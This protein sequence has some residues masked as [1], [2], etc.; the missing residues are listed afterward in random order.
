MMEV[1]KV[2]WSIIILCF[3]LEILFADEQSRLFFFLLAFE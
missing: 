2:G 3:V 1:I